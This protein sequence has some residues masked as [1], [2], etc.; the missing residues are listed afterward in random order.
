[1][2][3]T[4][5]LAKL[6]PAAAQPAHTDSNAA[7][8]APRWNAVFVNGR[9]LSNAELTAL[10]LRLGAAVPPGRYW[11]DA[12]GNWG[13]EGS[14][15]PMGNVNAA[16]GA[17]AGGARAGGDHYWSTRYAAGNCNDDNS[18]GYVYIPGQGTQSYG[19]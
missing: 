19:L 16:A 14:P 17:S 1:M 13:Y 8:A 15:L 2:S 5:F 10:A 4:D 7:H 6:F 11:V 3:F 18:A 12:V 9:E